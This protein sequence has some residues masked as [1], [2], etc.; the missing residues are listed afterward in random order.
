MS[1]ELLNKKRSSAD[2]K[3][4]KE[5]SNSEKEDEYEVE[6][7]LDKKVDKKKSCVLYL[8]KW[9]G[10]SDKYNSWEPYSNLDNCLDLLEKFEF[11]L[12]DEK[13]NNNNKGGKNKS[14]K[15]SKYEDSKALK[16][17]NNYN[18]NVKKVFLF[19]NFYGFFVFKIW[20]NINFN[21]LEEKL[22]KRIF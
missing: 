6:A 11:K 22:E 3:S 14:K 10:W 13:G 9:K 1:T 7:I 21:W 19:F 12:A 16:N 17:S 15:K 18:D 20:E 4:S 5:G 2:E 8:I